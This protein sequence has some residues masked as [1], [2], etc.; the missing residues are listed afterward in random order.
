MIGL[1]ADIVGILLIAFC[2]A[3]VLALSGLSA[4]AWTAVLAALLVTWLGWGAVLFPISAGLIGLTLL[5]RSFGWWEYIN[6]RRV[7][8]AEMAALFLLGLAHLVMANSVAPDQDVAI[9]ETLAGREMLVRVLTGQGGGKV[10]W[11]VLVLAKL[12]LPK[13]PASV[14]GLLFVIS[15][16]YALGLSW[17]HLF[18][19]LIS[20]QHRMTNK[21]SPRSG[22]SPV[23]SKRARGSVSRVRKPQR[24]P[25][26]R[27]F[28]VEAYR[29]TT[30]PK[31][32]KRMPLLPDLS[33]LSKGTS[34][35]PSERDINRNAVIIEHTLEEFGV[36]ATVVDFQ[37]GPT[38]TQFA[39][40]PGYTERSGPDGIARR[41][42]VRVSQI[43]N[44]SSD[45]ALALR[46]SRIRIQAPVPGQSYVGVE[47]PNRK[48]SF[49]SLRGILESEAF[50]SVSSP[51]AIAMG[52]DV[53]GAPV[54]ADLG[55][56]PHLLIAG[57]TGSG[58][59]VCIA[60]VVTGLV[61]N[62]TPEDLRVVLVD[63]KKV[64]LVR[65]NGLP[66]M[67]GRVEVELER[68]IGTLRWVLAEMGRRYRKFEE[69]PARDLGE[70]NR[71]IQRRKHSK[72]MPRIVVV[73]DELADLMMMAQDETEKTLIRLAQMARATGIHLIVATQRPS[74]DIV[75]GL[76]K[77]NFPARASFAVA[78]A[79][80]SR[81]VLDTT[82]AETLLGEGDMLF[83]SP[84]AASPLRLQ[85]VFVS[86]KDVDR[87]VNYW[88]GQSSELEASG[89][90]TSEINDSSED[91]DAPWEE[92]LARQAVIEDKDGQITQAIEIVRKHGTASAS[93]LQ[94]K[95]KVGYP[96]AARLMDELE[97]MGIVGEL[98]QGG[99]TREVLIGEGDDPIGM[100]AKSSQRQD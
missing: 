82:G 58:K 95:L 68:I 75:T 30:P 34:S 17:K 38:V 13:S 53:S 62:N 11:A 47:V 83:L 42:K 18:D 31:V 61:M 57:T 28:V 26:E 23:I 86:D 43:S 100:A 89:Y 88:K 69:V 51:L 71:K 98:R 44:L 45:L 50:Y 81:V 60:S 65:F 84:E 72:P 27:R 87:V 16:S 80:D 99:K 56:M 79:V 9:S 32:R 36:P 1:R 52:R 74:T 24:L 6:W 35:K 90:E 8:A 12:A 25:Y 64:E 5:A 55:S 70:Y 37:T 3:G 78:S 59:S 10:G 21:E 20:L 39:V 29:D 66:H 92:L 91:Q 22:T 2:V 63:P 77:A 93:L 76:I 15:S 41:N 54:V 49:V 46:T 96:R 48:K 14:L 94:R 4:G 73:I 33:L 85:A 7:I 40:Q 19:P 67:I 97:E